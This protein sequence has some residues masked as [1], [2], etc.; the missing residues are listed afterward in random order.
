M[1][2]EIDQEKL[3]QGGAACSHEELLEKVDMA[4]SSLGIPIEAVELAVK[5]IIARKNGEK[6]GRPRGNE[7]LEAMELYHNQ[8]SNLTPWDAAMQIKEKL[9]IDENQLYKWITQE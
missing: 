7:R 9:D 3:I 6:G 5:A 2:N 8:Y 1:V 4:L